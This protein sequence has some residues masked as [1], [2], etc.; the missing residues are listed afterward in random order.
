MDDDFEFNTPFPALP[1]VDLALWL[2]I[3]VAF[4]LTALVVT[5]IVLIA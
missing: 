2:N 5:A 3:I 1:G 4:V